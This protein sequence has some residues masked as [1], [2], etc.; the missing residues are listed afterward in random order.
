MQGT[1]RLFQGVVAGGLVIA[2][3]FLPRAA[4]QELKEI[5]IP[6]AHSSWGQFSEGAWNRVRVTT[7]TIGENGEVTEIRTTDTTTALVNIG[8]EY[9]TLKREE[10]NEVAGH[11]IVEPSET[12]HETFLGTEDDA[13]PM[14]HILPGGLI[15][16]E[17]RS[18]QSV[19]YRFETATST[20]RTVS[21]FY[22]CKSQSPYILRR[23]STTTNLET[24]KEVRSFTMQVVALDMPWNVLERMGSGAIGKTTRVEKVAIARM[25][26]KDP[27]GTTITWWILAPSIPGGKMQRASKKLDRTGRIVSRSTL[28]LLGY[29]LEPA[30]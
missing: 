30:P 13:A 3:L 18:Y 2:C 14:A 29:G 19:V 1:L 20:Q 24:G 17:G 28:E 27:A 10:V 16:L 21:T 26:S 8:N 25:T 22:Y 5:Q 4:A 12:I 6:A 15:T 7:E 9:I 11:R 23:S